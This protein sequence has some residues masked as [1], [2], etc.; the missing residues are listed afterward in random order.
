LNYTTDYQLLKTVILN[1]FLTIKKRFKMSKV[2]LTLGRKSVANLIIFARNIHDHMLAAAATFVTP[3]VTM[4]DLDKHTNELEKAQS[5]AVNG[6]HGNFVT[7]DAKRV[8]LE[9]DLKALGSYVDMTA[10]GSEAIIISAGMDVKKMS[11]NKLGNLTQPIIKKISCDL[12]G[13]L[14]INWYPVPRSIN[15]ALEHTSDFASGLWQNG[16]YSTSRTVTLS[17]LNS[18]T[19]YWIRVR[20]LGKN[21]LK[22]DWSDPAT[23]MVD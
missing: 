15:F 11:A 22:S 4:A 21:D 20:A 2:S 18:D 1:Y 6:N 7:R 23:K 16:T 14:T 5:D 13:T 8:I 12:K 19:R 3:P 17:G 10:K 9:G